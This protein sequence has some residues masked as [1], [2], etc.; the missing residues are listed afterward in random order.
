MK[1]IISV[2]SLALPTIAIAHPGHGGHGGSGF[3]ITHY[4]TEPDHAL[5]ALLGLAILGFGIY[6]LVSKK[7]T[8]KS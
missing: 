7:E 3:T 4:L 6:K 8:Q 1:K 2:F 5:G